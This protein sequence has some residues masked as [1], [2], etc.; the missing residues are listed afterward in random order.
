MSSFQWAGENIDMFFAISV[1]GVLF[2]IIISVIYRQSTGRRVKSPSKSEVV[3]EERN[4][5]GRSL[6]TWWT[7]LG[8]ANNCLVVSVTHSMLLIRP[9]FPFNLMFLPEIFDLEHSIDLTEITNAAKHPGLFRQKVLVEFQQGS[10]GGSFELKL[11][12]PDAFLRAVELSF[13]DF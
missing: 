10:R 5:S 6:R 4:A 9:F 13:D 8:G 11:R 2:L 7:R 12:D 1:G 3:F